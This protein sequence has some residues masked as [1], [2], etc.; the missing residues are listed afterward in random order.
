MRLL[1]AL[2]AASFALSAFAQTSTKPTP[3]PPAP[4]PVLAPDPVVHADRTVTFRYTNPDATT[5]GLAL[6]GV[7]EPIPMLKGPGGGWTLTTEAL[8]PEI[9]SYHFEVDGRYELD[10][11]NVFVKAGVLNAG[12][13]FLVP[14]SIAPEPWE[15]TA[16]PHGEVQQHIF[17]THVV[18]GLDKDQ[19]QFF[20]YT[21]PGYD[22]RSVVKYPVLY[23]LHGWSDTAGGWTSIGQANAIFDNLIA[24]GKARPMLVVMPL[25]YGD[26]SFVRKGWG[27]WNV[28]ADID[29]NTALFTQS[30]LTEV[31]PQVE[32]LYNVAPGRE[33][34]AIAGLSMGG[35][36]AL[37]VGL[38]HTGM[39]EYVGGFSAA[40]HL[41]KPAGLT[42]LDPRTA[43]LKLLWIACGTE[44]G[45]IEPN[46][47]LAAYLKGEGMPVTEIET[48]GMHTW[49]VWR[50]NLVNFAPLLFQAGSERA[51]VPQSGSR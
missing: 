35:L 38:N 41:L 43:D 47:K 23:L 26:M 45:L 20:V 5:V 36:E 25:G 12:N 34:R 16:V 9:Y 31:M 1:P 8:K 30:L 2:L 46:R 10:A 32:K 44:D 27:E 37:S 51:S 39:F 21:P 15:T 24:Q 3:P 28:P 50:D 48:P 18:Q 22:P 17:T 49:M 14:G 33:N 42:G 7:R 4:P 11:H 13:G 29:H 6:E 40:V 19:D